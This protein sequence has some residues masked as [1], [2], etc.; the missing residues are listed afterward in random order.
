MLIYSEPKVPAEKAKPAVTKGTKNPFIPYTVM[1][2]DTVNT[3]AIL[4]QQLVG[5]CPLMC[6]N[7]IH[8]IEF[9]VFMYFLPGGAAILKEKPKG[10]H[11]KKGT[12]VVL[13]ETVIFVTGIGIIVIW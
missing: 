7:Y 3:S 1:F 8:S 6:Y 9:Y 12:L 4:C 10:V 13:V 11:V 5:H 2:G